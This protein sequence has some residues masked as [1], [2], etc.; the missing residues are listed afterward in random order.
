MKKLLISQIKRNLYKPRK[1]I[2]CERISKTEIIIHF[3]SAKDASEIPISF[4]Q[5]FNVTALPYK[6]GNTHSYKVTSK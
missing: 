6:P 3:E 5:R 2:N 1:G 4:F